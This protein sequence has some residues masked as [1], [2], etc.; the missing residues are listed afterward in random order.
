MNA[1]NEKRQQRDGKDDEADERIS[2]VRAEFL[3]PAFLH[4]GQIND[5]LSGHDNIR[6]Q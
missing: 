1:R 5:E 3:S 4:F 2:F 6:Q